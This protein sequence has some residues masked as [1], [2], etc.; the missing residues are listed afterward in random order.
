MDKHLWDASK[1]FAPAFPRQSADEYTIQ[2]TRRNRGEFVSALETASTSEMPGYYSVYSFPRGHSKQGNIPEV[3]CIFID[4][5]VKGDEYQ[6]N[7]N[8]PDTDTSFGAWKR[9]MSKLLARARMIAQAI[10]DEG[11]ADHFRVTLSGHKGLHLYLDFPT[12]A[13]ENGDIGQFKNGLGTYGETVMD[14]L[15]AS[16]GGL[17]I[18]PWVDVDA[19]DLGRLA[20]HPNTRHH[21]AAYDD[22]ERWCVPVTVAELADLHVEDYLD[23]TTEPRWDT[24]FKRIP[25]ESAG[26]KAT[27]AIRNAASSS[28]STGSRSSYDPQAVKQYKANSNDDI[29][30]SDVLF[31]TS[32][33]PCIKAFRERDDAY[34]YGDTSRAMELSIM[35]RFIEMQVP[36][37]VMHEFFAPIPG[38]DDAYTQELIED[39]IGRGY[40]EFNC[41]NIVG[42]PDARGRATRFCLQDDCSIYRRSDDLEA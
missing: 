4:L 24:R 25:S 17:N 3:N 20:R 14:W 40:R 18:D 23:Y 8:Q 41:E 35:G 32:N 13:P 28:R 12:I 5:D 39:L 31:L 6:P 15:D 30:L 16:A 1:V 29:D 37:D 34:D 33:K 27:Q 38:Y 36:I 19:S 21:G 10:L 9:S 22:A 11:M 26:Q 2:D 7:P 42:G